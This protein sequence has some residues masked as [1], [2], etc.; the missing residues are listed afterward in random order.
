MYNCLL[1]LLLFFKWHE[2]PQILAVVNDVRKM[3]EKKSCMLNMDRLSTCCCCCYLF[4][5]VVLFCFLPPN[6]RLAVL[7]V[8]S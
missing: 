3:T 8:G 4:V 5:H 7:V 6:I 1:L 2:L